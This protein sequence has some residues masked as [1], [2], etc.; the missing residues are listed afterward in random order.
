[1]PDL[2]PIRWWNERLVAAARGGQRTKN[3]ANGGGEK[4]GRGVDCAGDRRDIYEKCRVVDEIG[5]MG[6]KR[7]LLGGGSWRGHGLWE[8]VELEG[9]VRGRRDAR[10]LD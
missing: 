7:A 10:E 5:G 3:G 2:G 9:G 4:P 1:V 6:T 8:L